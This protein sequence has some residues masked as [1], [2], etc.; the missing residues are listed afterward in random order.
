[1]NSA[2]PKKQTND[3]VVESSFFCDAGSKIDKD[4]NKSTPEASDMEPAKK[5][6][7]SRMDSCVLD[8][9][10]SMKTM[11]ARWHDQNRRSRPRSFITWQ[12]DC[13]DIPPRTHAHEEIPTRI[14]PCKSLVELM[15]LICYEQGKRTQPGG[16]PFFSRFGLRMKPSGNPLRHEFDSFELPRLKRA[17]LSFIAS[18]ILG[19]LTKRLFFPGATLL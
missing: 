10:L 12:Q 9:S 19:F 16:Y 6:L 1:M 2:P 7:F 4:E 11:E 13:K 8:H 5:E 17:F 15:T 14:H 3:S 18:L